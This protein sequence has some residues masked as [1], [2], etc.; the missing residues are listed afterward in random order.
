MVSL[1]HFALANSWETADLEKWG[2]TGIERAAR[3]NGKPGRMVKALR[4]SGFLDGSII[5]DW[6]EA[7]GKLVHERLRKRE[8]RSKTVKI[9]SRTVRPTSRTVRPL[10]RKVDTTVPYSTVQDS[11]VQNRTGPDSKTSYKVSVVPSVGPKIS[12]GATTTKS[13]N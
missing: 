3:W 8:E 12:V 10:G 1:W 4:D 2:D 9:V 6:M 5:H 7:A 11:T 13:S